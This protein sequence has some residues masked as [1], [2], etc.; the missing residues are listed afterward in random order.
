MLPPSNQKSIQLIPFGAVADCREKVHEKIAQRAY[1]IFEQRGHTPGHDL[2]DWIQAEHELFKHVIVGIADTDR[3]LILSADVHRIKDVKVAV[4]PTK[5][6]ILGR[7]AKN[8]FG[9]EPGNVEVFEPIPLPCVVTPAQAT[10]SVKC[11][12]LEVVLPKVMLEKSK[13]P[14]HALAWAA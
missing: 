7:M 11:G 8:G 5:V 6:T 14:E 4:N 10:A 13:S 12:C 3:E 1:E 2:D 9:R